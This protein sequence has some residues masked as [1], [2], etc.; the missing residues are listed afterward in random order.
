MKANEGSRRN[1]TSRPQPT[2]PTARYKTVALK[3][4]TYEKVVYWADALR[5]QWGR[6]TIGEA[7]DFLADNAGVPQEAE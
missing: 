7:I 2:P 1:Y 5:E 3:P 4:E 6:C